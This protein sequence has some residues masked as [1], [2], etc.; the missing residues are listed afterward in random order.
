MS[1]EYQQLVQLRLT[2]DVFWALQTLKAA[3]DSVS[4]Q[5]RV[6]LAT[7]L[8]HSP[9]RP[10]YLRN[11]ELAATSRYLKILFMIDSNLLWKLY[12]R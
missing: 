9:L 10:L 4:S 7:I 12:L 11:I 6:Q 2:N 8:T 5:E 3:D 1:D